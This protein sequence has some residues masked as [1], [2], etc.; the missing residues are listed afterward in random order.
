VTFHLIGNHVIDFESDDRASGIVYCRPEHQVDGL[1]IV[2]PMQYWDRYE[3]RDGQWF[4]RSRSPHVFYAADVLERPQ[5]APDRFRFPDNPMLT[6]ADLPERWPSWTDY[7]ERQR[8]R[9][10]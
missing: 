1:W 5:D 2:M 8:A 9:A 7:W 10:R 6:R 3:K 4:F